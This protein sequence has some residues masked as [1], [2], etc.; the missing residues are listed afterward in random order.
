MH[1]FVI[2]GEALLIRGKIAER[3][4][5][6]YDYLEINWIIEIHIANVQ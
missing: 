2:N 1:D 6:S 4:G 5:F 3:G